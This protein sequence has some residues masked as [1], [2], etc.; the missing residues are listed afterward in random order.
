MRQRFANERVPEEELHEE[1]YVAQELHIGRRQRAQQ[2]ILSE[3]READ[4][5]AEHRGA[6]D[7]DERHAQR[8]AE[9]DRERAEITVACAIA[10]EERLADLEAGLALQEGKAAGDAPCLEIGSGVR[11]EKTERRRDC[12]ERERLI[13]Y[14]PPPF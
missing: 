13:R 5:H 4:Q 10:Q 7:A 1:R 14:R 6:R 2:S 9:A 11:Y 8:V 12:G 3:A